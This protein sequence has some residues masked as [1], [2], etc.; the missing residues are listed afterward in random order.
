MNNE[1]T[2][3]SVLTKNMNRSTIS[4]VNNIINDIRLLQDTVTFDTSNS[5]EC[6][7]DG[8]VDM[9]AEIRGRISLELDEEERLYHEYKAR[10]NNS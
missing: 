3:N 8:I 2:I 5:S 10:Q 6:S 9:L 7:L 1:E 4:F